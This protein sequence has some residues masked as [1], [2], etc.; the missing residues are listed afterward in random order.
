MKRNTSHRIFSKGLSLSI[1]IAALF[2]VNTGCS[3]HS[4]QRNSDFPK[5]THELITQGP[6]QAYFEHSSGIVSVYDARS[7]Q[8]YYQVGAEAA[9][10]FSDVQTDKNTITGKLN[11]EGK[12]FEVTWSFEE[13]HTLICNI[14]GDTDLPILDDAPLAYPYAFAMNTEDSYV[15]LP[16]SGGFLFKLDGSDMPDSRKEGL[17]YHLYT[18][19]HSP[20]AV[21]GLTDLDDGMAVVFD[22][23]ADAT[24]TFK[25]FTHPEA[26]SG[27]APAITWRGEKDKLGYN[28]Q[29]R[30]HIS[31]EGSFVSLAKYYR[32]KVIERGGFK[33]LK[34]KRK[35]RPKIDMLVAAPHTWMMSSKYTR[36]NELIDD[37]KK[38]GID[39]IVIKTDPH[40][41]F[42]G[43]REKGND[44]EVDQENH[45]K[46]LERAEEHGY[47][48]GKYMTYS[49]I[50]PFK[51]DQKWD[52]LHWNHLM[53]R[54]DNYLP[55]SGLVEKN[56][57]RKTGWM[58]QG[59]RVCER[60]GYEEFIPEHFE[61]FKDYIL[62][63]NAFFFDVEGALH[64]HE[65]YDPNHPMTRRDDVMWRQKRAEYFREFNP[66]W[67]IGT[68]SGADYLLPTYDWVMGPPTNTSYADYKALNK[69]ENSPHYL[70]GWD[71]NADREPPVL[72][73]ESIVDA[74]SKKF[75]LNAAVRI[76]FYDL[77]HGDQ[78]VTVRRWEY[79]N[80][81]MKSVWRFKDLQNMLWGTPP[82]YSISKEIWDSEKEELVTSIHTV[83]NWL[84]QI[85]YDEMTNFEF[86][87][88]DKMVQ[89]S[90]FSS[91]KSIIVNFKK[92]PV[93]INGQKIEAEGFLIL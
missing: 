24:Y 64:L 33:S 79:T 84:E 70:G 54:D 3:S 50:R 14:G 12:E 5:E 42:P 28:R 81:K 16:D 25:P 89:K 32:Q 37:F 91:G 15:V 31:D 40:V 26:G 43:Y 55:Y 13:D 39:K 8:W 93:D 30:F 35:E 90:T 88:D 78:V 61:F 67:V 68:E 20:M 17:P 2:S 75:G 83:C 47:L 63:H 49:S 85:G 92:Q 34:D 72:Y 65:C 74:Q 71:R 52:V 10:T 6:I 59:V 21:Y 29:V 45:Y 58:G 27:Y 46:F 18:H 7:N 57:K 19:Y 62:K 38:H 41:N 36:S 77:V 66:E 87:T 23:P 76:P 1:V 73:K 80:N 86:M 60:F 4:E 69:N 56:G 53:L 48:V 22:T 9:Y 11:T 82:V 51:K 44:V